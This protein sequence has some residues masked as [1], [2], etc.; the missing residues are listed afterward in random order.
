MSLAAWGHRV[1]AMALPSWLGLHCEALK[2]P[3]VFKIY[4]PV[5]LKAARSL[6]AASVF[7]EDFHEWSAEESKRLFN[8][9][10]LCS[11]QFHILV[12]TMIMHIVILCIIYL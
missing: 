8:T 5:L 4:G 12:C 6:R 11:Y 2:G 10:F 7:A 3:E 9:L 1:A